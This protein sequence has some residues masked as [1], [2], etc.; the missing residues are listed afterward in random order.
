MNLASLRKPASNDLRDAD[1]RDVAA[2]CWDWCEASGDGRY[3]SLGRTLKSI[4]G[5]WAEHD[6]RG[7][8]PT[9][10]LDDLGLV[11]RRDLPRIIK[12]NWPYGWFRNSSSE[13]AM[14]HG[15]NGPSVSQK[16]RWRMS[17]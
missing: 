11:L 5:W 12:R 8:V 6:E 15:G 10:V 13:L 16:P 7:G 14:V 4:H 17:S 3:C 2:L 9:A 1:L